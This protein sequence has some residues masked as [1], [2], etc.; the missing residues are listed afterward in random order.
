MVSERS[1]HKLSE[2]KIIFDAYLVGF[3]NKSGESSTLNIMTHNL[4]Y[5]CKKSYENLGHR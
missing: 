2:F 1:V 4:L 5:M 3:N